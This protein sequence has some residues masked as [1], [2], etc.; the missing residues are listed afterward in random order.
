MY[1][2]GCTVS[3]CDVTREFACGDGWCVGS[4]KRCD[5]RSDCGDGSDELDC[6][7]GSDEIDCGDGL[8]E[9]DCGASTL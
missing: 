7:G 9:I 5:G 3:G 6:G 8:D 1:V 2:C 4:S